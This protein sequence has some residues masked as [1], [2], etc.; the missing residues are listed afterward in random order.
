[1]NKVMTKFKSTKFYKPVLI[2]GLLAASILLVYGSAKVAEVVINRP[3]P[4][5]ISD[6]DV[7][8]SMK[9]ELSE[10]DGSYIGKSREGTKV[11][12]LTSDNEEVTQDTS[13]YE[14]IT[15]GKDTSGGELSVATKL[16]DL[17]Y[18][19]IKGILSELG[20]GIK[21]GNSISSEQLENISSKYDVNITEITQMIEQYQKENTSKSEKIKSEI[22]LTEQELRKLINQ[23]QNTLA[24][25]IKNVENKANASVTTANKASSDA[26]SA[27]TKANSAQQ[28]ADEASKSATNAN[29]TASSAS[30]KAE[31]ASSAASSA[32]K[33]ASTAK[34]TANQ[35]NS[36]ANKANSRLDVIEDKMATAGNVEGSYDENTHTLTITLTR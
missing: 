34:D 25:S 32:A 1:M 11:S 5:F 2:T 7:D 24:S 9:Y 27:A 35:A 19:V 12:M 8:N 14:V 18:N 26:N 22:G 21:N 10:E 33:D 29:T 17:E 6:Y 13:D 31:A 30:S 3:S 16:D 23:L 4:D 36:S 28:K 20:E 15:T